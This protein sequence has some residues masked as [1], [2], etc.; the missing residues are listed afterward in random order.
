MKKKMNKLWK[1]PLVMALVA[2][3]MAVAGVAALSF[4]VFAESHL[5]SKGAI[6]MENTDLY[7]CTAD[8]EMLQ[9]EMDTLY[10]EIPEITGTFLNTGSRKESI[11]SRGNINY[12]D[13]TIAIYATDLVYLADEIDFLESAY[14]S[15][16]MLALKDIGTYFTNEGLITHSRDGADF[17]VESAVRLS[18]SKLYEAILQSQSVEH[19]ATQQA[20]NYEGVPLY[21]ATEDDQNHQN[22]CAVTTI[23]NG[24]PLFVQAV[25]P[26]NMTAGAAAWVNGEIVIGNG[27]DNEAFYRRGYLDGYQQVMNGISIEYQYH[28]HSGSSADGSGCYTKAEYHKHSDSCYVEG[29]HSDSC[30][31]HMEFH[32]Y[33]CGSVHDWDGDGHGCDGYQVYDCGGHRE[34]ICKATDAVTGYSLNCGMTEETILCAVIVFR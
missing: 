5:Q 25:T 13:G 24:F 9:S 21:Y 26:A 7:L 15:N 3:V 31:Y 22:I 30:L 23:D 12:A 6:A 32:D 2:I 8:V 11:K 4:P 17:S 19:L 33:D 18:F 20:L 14:K 34:L 28:V 10:Q 29:G 16:T 27:A 1:K